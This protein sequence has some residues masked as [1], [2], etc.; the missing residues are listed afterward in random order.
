MSIREAN[1]ADVRIR[2][3]RVDDAA[4]VLQAAHESIA[5]LE[6]WMPWCH[7]NYSM[8][9]SQ[10]WLETQATAF[11]QGTAFEFAIVSASG[12]YLGGCG[13]NQID[14][15]N[16]RANLGYWVRSME[17]R[18]G[19]ATVAV[20]LI[21]DWAFENTDLVRLEIVIACGNLASHRVA[22]KAGAA[23]EGLLTRRLVLHGNVHD[24]TMFSLTRELH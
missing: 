7:P 14:K 22:A 18:K 8:D 1:G 3:Y 23:I 9:E 10:A 17:T 19:V 2:R 13:L 21:R 20:G 15:A 24:A 6:P 16:K 5:E 4:T 11:E 12:R